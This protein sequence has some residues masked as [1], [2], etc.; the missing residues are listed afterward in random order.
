M[1][2]WI[3]LGAFLLPI[4]LAGCVSRPV[5]V[6]AAPP[7]PAALAD[8]NRQGY[9]AGVEAAQRDIAEGRRPDADRHPRFRNPPVPPPL[10]QDY[11]HG[12]IAGY[13]QVIRGGAPGPGY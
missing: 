3:A 5:V 9:N 7:P 6:Y 12:F 8:A 13:D 2:K 11:R 10:I 4:S 1:R